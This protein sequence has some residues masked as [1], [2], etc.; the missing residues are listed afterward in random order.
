MDTDK[1]HLLDIM[2]FKQF[3]SQLRPDL[4]P[5]TWKMCKKK[6]ASYDRDSSGFIDL[7]EFTSL[8]QDIFGPLA[9]EP[10]NGPR[11]REVEESR[12]VNSDVWFCHSKM[13]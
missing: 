13:C 8:Y 10:N 12:S 5:A 2:E 3:M 9:D 7:K 6:F 11:K 4:K 1:S